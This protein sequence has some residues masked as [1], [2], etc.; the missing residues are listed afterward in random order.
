M[1]EQML[2]LFIQN[3]FGDKP[4]ADVLI[5]GGHIAENGIYEDMFVWPDIE[6]L[7]SSNEWF[8]L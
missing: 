4:I 2:T 5:E 8:Q 6:I 7:S 3:I 1:Q